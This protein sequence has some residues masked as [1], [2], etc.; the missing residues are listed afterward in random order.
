MIPSWVAG[1]AARDAMQRR[2][3]GGGS[4]QGSLKG[5]ASFVGIAFIAGATLSQASEAKLGGFLVWMLAALAVIAAWWAAYRAR[6][7]VGAV[8]GMALAVLAAYSVDVIAAGNGVGGW[9]WPT[10]VLVLVGLDQ[11]AWKK[12]Q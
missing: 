1:A 2:Y 11:W 8:A 9:F 6:G 12:K 4:S 3:G 7:A 5:V 10:A